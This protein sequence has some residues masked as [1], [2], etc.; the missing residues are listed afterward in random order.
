MPLIGP[1]KYHRTLDG[2]ELT[3]ARERLKLSQEEFADKCGWTH[4]YQS[5][6]EV[7]EMHEI[8]AENA[9]KILELISF[10]N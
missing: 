8:S 5:R 1:S 4:Q 2:V 6:L 7:P 10:C 9:E 3:K